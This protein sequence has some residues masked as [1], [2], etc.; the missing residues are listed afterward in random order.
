[1]L[2]LIYPWTSSRILNRT[3]EDEPLRTGTDRLDRLM[4]IS[5]ACSTHG[6]PVGS[7]WTGSFMILSFNTVSTDT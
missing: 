2:G 3:E 7:M 1:M 4:I 5:G 6:M